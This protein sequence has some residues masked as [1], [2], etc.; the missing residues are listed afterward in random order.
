M[1]E[2]RPSI[3]G[4]FAMAELL[5]SPQRPLSI[6]VEDSVF[7]ESSTESPEDASPSLPPVSDGHERQDHSLLSPQGHDGPHVRSV[8]MENGVRDEKGDVATQALKKARQSRSVSFLAPDLYVTSVAVENGAG[9][10]KEDVAKQATKKERRSRSVSFLEP[11]LHVTSVA[12]ENGA[13]DEKK[14]VAEQA[15]KKPHF[16]RS[17]S[18]REP[19]PAPTD[20]EK[21]LLDRVVSRWKRVSRRNKKPEESLSSENNRVYFTACGLQ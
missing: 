6:I 12:V 15:T 16:S 14:D 8:I 3:A 2:L 9:G 7:A 1:A 10:E 20:K 21:V 13:R 19:G 11:D 18:I 17:V 5:H 4:D